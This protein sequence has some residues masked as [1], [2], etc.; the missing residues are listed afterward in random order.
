[1]LLSPPSPASHVVNALPGC[2]QR[3]QPLPPVPPH[4][5]AAP[6]PLRPVA[7]RARRPAAAHPGATCWAAVA[8][9]WHGHP[10]AWWAHAHPPDEVWDLEHPENLGVALSAPKAPPKKCENNPQRPP[11]GGFTSGE[12]Q[13]KTWAT[14]R[15]SE[16]LQSPGRKSWLRG[17]KGSVRATWRDPSNKPP[18]SRQCD[19]YLRAGQ[20]GTKGARWTMMKHDEPWNMKQEI[21]RGS[22]CHGLWPYMHSNSCDTLKLVA[23]QCELNT[24]G[25]T[26]WTKQC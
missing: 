1:M 13:K 8:G 19:W 12:K 15:N 23:L 6:P 9:R 14:P 16:I 5:V 25:Q 18:R 24:H 3:S 21:A 7:G 11:R 4:A 10:M 22:N 26:C 17:A 20:K 2:A